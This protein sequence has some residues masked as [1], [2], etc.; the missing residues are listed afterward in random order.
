M[1]EGATGSISAPVMFRSTT[2]YIKLEF[3][4]GK[5]RKGI[6]QDKGFTGR[7]SVGK[8]HIIVES[9]LGPD[10]SKKNEV[11]LCFHKLIF[12]SMDSISPMT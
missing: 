2:G 8:Y 7:F 6:G 3:S 4:T 11:R 1:G 9:S 12:C 10:L 5:V